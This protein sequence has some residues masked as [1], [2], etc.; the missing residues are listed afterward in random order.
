MPLALFEQF[1][2]CSNLSKKFDSGLVSGEE[3][4]VWEDDI[5]ICSASVQNPSIRFSFGLRSFQL[6]AYSVSVYF[7]QFGTVQI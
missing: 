5:K 7:A 4:Q 3:V 2:C 1:N 6:V